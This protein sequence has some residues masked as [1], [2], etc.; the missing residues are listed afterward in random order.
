MSPVSGH[1]PRKAEMLAEAGNPHLTAPPK[2]NRRELYLN[3]AM[4]GLI[5][6]GKKTKFKGIRGYTSTFVYKVLDYFTGVDLFPSDFSLS[7]L[8]CIHG[9]MSSLQISSISSFKM[10]AVNKL[11]FS[12]LTLCHIYTG[13]NKDHIQEVFCN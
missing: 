13:F 12:Q 10:N 4:K 9:Y 1:Q 3:I 8:K 5:L 6:R 7:L 11:H 2:H